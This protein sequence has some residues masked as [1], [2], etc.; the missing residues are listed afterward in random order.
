MQQVSNMET[1][2]IESTLKELQRETELSMEELE[3]LLADYISNGF[4]EYVHNSME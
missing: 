4:E 2:H 1:K 3:N